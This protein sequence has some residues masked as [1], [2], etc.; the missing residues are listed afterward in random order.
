MRR[1][2][3]L[4]KL[5]ICLPLTGKW[6]NWYLLSLVHRSAG[7][8]TAHTMITAIAAR[9]HDNAPGQLPE[10]DKNNAYLVSRTVTVGTLLFNPFILQTVVQLG[11]LERLQQ[12]TVSFPDYF[13]ITPAHPSNCA[14]LLISERGTRYVRTRTGVE[15]CK[16]S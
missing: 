8:D 16:Y 12:L 2:P 6:L 13:N 5:K 9:L 10:T 15:W 1:E 11:A 7:D 14:C 3:A 4:P